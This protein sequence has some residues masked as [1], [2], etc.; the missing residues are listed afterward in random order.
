M[1]PLGCPD[2]LLIRY[3]LPR[4]RAPSH[5]HFL[6]KLVSLD[7]LLLRFFLGL[8]FFWGGKRNAQCVRIPSVGSFARVKPTK[9]YYEILDDVTISLEYHAPPPLS[10]TPSLFRTP[11]NKAGSRLP[12]PFVAS[13]KLVSNRSGFRALL[14]EVILRLGAL[15][16][17]VYSIPL[18]YRVVR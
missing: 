17:A 13:F 14:S 18:S 8:L 12:R 3:E 5:S 6:A 1:T 16:I 7:F 10:F 4:A 9:S 15:I 2:C 11:R